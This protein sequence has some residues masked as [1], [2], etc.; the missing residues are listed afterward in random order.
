M[1]RLRTKR[2]ELR[3]LTTSDFAEWAEV[4]QRCRDWLAKWEPRPLENVPD[5]SSELQAFATRC[6]VRERERSL[7]TAF[8]FGLWH[9][10]RFCGEI[11][12]SHV[13][14][15]AF[16]SAHVGYWIDERLA[17]RGLIAEGLLAVFGFAF[18]RAGLHRVQVSIM[19]RNA[20]SLRV[21]EKLGLRSEGIAQGYIQIDG[22]WEDHIRFGLTVEEWHARRDEMAARV[23]PVGSREGGRRTAQR[24][25]SDSHR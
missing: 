3:P 22:D 11:N 7:G 19:P 4:R 23:Q 15:G 13:A 24:S 8:D 16:Q 18:E 9:E 20:A 2:L 1:S 12:I 14:R 21:A 17:G 10:G 6:R 5:P 25:S